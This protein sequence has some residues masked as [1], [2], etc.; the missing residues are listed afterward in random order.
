M[1]WPAIIMGLIA[2]GVA[3]GWWLDHRGFAGI[4]SD[5]ADAKRDADALRAKVKS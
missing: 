3:I 4:K 1:N 2:I 5:L